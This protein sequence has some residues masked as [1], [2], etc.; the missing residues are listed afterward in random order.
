[1]M[2]SYTHHPET[3]HHRRD[4]TVL[5]SRSIFIATAVMSALAYLI[6]VVFIALAPRATMTFFGYILHA[7]LSSIARSVSVGGFFIGLL[8][9]SLGTGLYAALI[10][11]LYNRLL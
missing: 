11:R 10:A 3:H 8:A 2:T 7:D 6:C 4:I 1:M 9:W 5:R